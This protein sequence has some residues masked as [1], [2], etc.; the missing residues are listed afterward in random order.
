MQQIEI[1]DRDDESRVGRAS[2]DLVRRLVAL[3]IDG[4]GPLPPAAE[5]A[6]AVRARTDSDEVAVDS[7]VAT[8]TRV[9]AVGGFVTGLGGFVTLP[10]ALPANVVGYYLVA[11]RTVA[12]IASVRGYDL[13][14]PQVRD[15]V[16]ATLVEV[17]A[18]SLLTHVGLGGSGG[19]VTQVLST[20]L[21]A[22]AVMVLDKA[23]GFQ[24]VSQLGETVL[25]RLG[26]GVPLAGGLVGAASDALMLR[27]TSW[28][29][30]DAFPPQEAPA[31][32]GSSS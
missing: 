10:V 15:A 29:A 22:P 25:R 9:V 19:L 11:A 4:I 24:V 7:L 16:L 31:P 14:R 18:R 2:A 32:G 6:R 1:S 28:A 23:I 21:S 26:R 27:R 8:A 13:S 5:A 20:Q 3:A 17:D 12:G 30:S